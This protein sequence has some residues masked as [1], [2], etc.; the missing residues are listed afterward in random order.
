MVNKKNNSTNLEKNKKDKDT[1]LSEKKVLFQN[2]FLNEIIPY[3]VIV[4]AVIIIRSYIVTP[5][6]VRGD[7][8]DY[9]LHDIKR[10]DIIVINEEKDLIIKR[11][12]GLP[13]DKVEYID[14]KLYINNHK[15]KDDYGIGN[16]SDFTLEDICEINDD[17]CN[18]KIPSGMYLA[19]GDNREVS[20]DSRVKG[21][22]SKNKILGKATLRIWPITKIGLVK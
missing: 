22:F 14:N 9:R 21:L 12:I 2:K 1:K 3:I 15:V 5:V 20:A 8:M 18:G 13:G 6:I 11:V 16:T 19:L 4:I 10:Y 17:R 7:S